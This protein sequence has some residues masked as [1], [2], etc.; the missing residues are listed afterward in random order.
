VIL[1]K[2]YGLILFFFVFLISSNGWLAAVLPSVGFAGWLFGG[3][4]SKPLLGDFIFIQQKCPL[5]RGN[6]R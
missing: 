5:V 1:V 6:L 3:M 4:G 2:N